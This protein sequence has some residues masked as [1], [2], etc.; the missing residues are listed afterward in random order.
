[1]AN[2]TSPG[3]VGG[4]RPSSFV[5]RME[6]LGRLVGTGKIETRVTVAQA[7]AARQERSDFY[8]H[9]RGG[10]AHALRD[11]ILEKHKVHIQRVAQEL[12]RGNTQV[13]Y[14]RFGEDV[15]AKYGTDAPLELNN[16]R[17]S[18]AV[19]VL[20]GGR[21]IYTRPAAQRRLTRRELNARVRLHHFAKL[22][23][24]FNAPRRRR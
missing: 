18:A 22:Q 3:M 8:D 2:Y 16:L 7:Y 4:N 20:A 9:P 13:L 10:K 23:S 1:M 21:T 12:F 19:K 17:R 15:S 11:A 5:E 24:R 6:E 14:I